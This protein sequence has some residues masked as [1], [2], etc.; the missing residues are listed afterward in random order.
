MAFVEGYA[1]MAQT[2]KNKLK[3]AELK[4]TSNPTETNAWD[5]VYNYDV[6]Y[7][8]R[9]KGEE[10]YIMLA[11]FQGIAEKWA[12]SLY[13][14]N[15]DVAAKTLALL[16]SDFRFDISGISAPPESVQFMH[17]MVVDCPVD[18]YVYDSVGNLVATLKDGTESDVTNSHGR[19]V[20]LYD[21]FTDEYAK[22]ICLLTDDNYK[23]EI[24]GVDKGLVNLSVA[25]KDGNE[26][27]KYQ[28]TNQK[29]D[30][31]TVFITTV[32]DIKS[33]NGYT[34]DT[35]G[36][37]MAES[38]GVLTAPSSTVVHVQS[39]EIQP[40]SIT[41]CKGTDTVLGVA[42]VPQNATNQSVAWFTENSDVAT[43]KNGKLTAVSQGST[44][45]TAL[46]ADKDVA[47]IMD[48]CVVT[49]VDH[50]M[51]DGVCTN[52]GKGCDGH[53]G[54]VADCQN[55]AVCSI[56]GAEYGELDMTNHTGTLEW[57][58]TAE[59]HSSKYICCVTVSI[60]EENHS[61]TDGKCDKCEYMC[62]HTDTDENG[63]CIVC[64]KEIIPESTPTPS[65]DVTPSPE[66][67]VS[68]EVTPTPTPQPSA[69][70][71]PTN[72]PPAV[73][74]HYWNLTMQMDSTHHWYQCYD[75]GAEDEYG[76][77]TSN[78]NGYCSKCGYYTA[79]V[80]ESEPTPAVSP[81]PDVSPSTQPS[82]EPIVQP[83]PTTTPQPENTQTENNQS[84]GVP[85][86]GIGIGA[87]VL[88]A[89]IILFKKKKSEE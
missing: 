46:S 52:C 60:E 23:I 63:V 48:Q 49:V 17:K 30:K 15:K 20:V 50:T 10:Y 29:T 34:I 66:P 69:E 82:A 54:G 73:H 32:E 83:S 9:E 4:F 24:I 44:T 39:V 74:T 18:V 45:I 11:D 5:F 51:S 68:P 71:T 79:P 85:V 86:A 77:H 53:I 42:V 72:P 8:L 2:F 26:T 76:V 70:P 43:I 67:S 61:W 37:G 55:K 19:F 84:G 35:D 88:I 40:Q 75:C 81:T 7:M 33:G 59:K 28:F 31:D 58:Q 13:T 21:M 6:L 38:T 1:A 64:G 41:V 36:D 56:C 47:E 89:I 65:P 27:P 80:I 14:D 16:R 62:G 22:V 78:A 12:D 57:V 25:Y 3:D 87:A